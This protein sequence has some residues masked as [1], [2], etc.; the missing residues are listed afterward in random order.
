MLRG[1]S[2][3]PWIDSF[4][5]K[6]LRRHLSIVVFREYLSENGMSLDTL[7]AAEFFENH[8]DL[9]CDYVLKYKITDNLI[10]TVIKFEYDVLRRELFQRILFL[11]M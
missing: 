4:N 1:D 3:R 2:R 10:P 8:I 7:P 6:L 5:P 9:F 11:K